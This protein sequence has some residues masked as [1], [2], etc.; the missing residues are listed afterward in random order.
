MAALPYDSTAYQGNNIPN[1][2]SLALGPILLGRVSFG[3]TL[4]GMQGIA[5]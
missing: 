4:A 3:N 5:V 2:T 1:G